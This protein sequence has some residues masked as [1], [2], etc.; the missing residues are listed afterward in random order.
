MTPN[1]RGLGFDV[2][3]PVRCSEGEGSRSPVDGAVDFDSRQVLWDAPPSL[4]ARRQR[5]TIFE[6]SQCPVTRT[7]LA[8]CQMGPRKLRKPLPCHFAFLLEPIPCLLGRFGRLRASGHFVFGR[9]QP[10]HCVRNKVFAP[11]VPCRRRVSVGRQGG[12]SLQFVEET[13]NRVR[14]VV[15]RLRTALELALVHWSPKVECFS[16]RI[17]RMID[18]LY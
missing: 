10:P 15:P 3:P 5:L 8:Q 14:V 13:I 1:S 6:A 9:L 11:T 4:P 17:Q 18:R 7:D 12:R 16:G 2:H